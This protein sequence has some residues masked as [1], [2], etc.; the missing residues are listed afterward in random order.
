MSSLCPQGP[1]GMAQDRRLG[2]T[3]WHHP[4]GTAALVDKGAS[5]EAGRPGLAA[6][7]V[8]GDGVGES[9]GWGLRRSSGPRSDL[10]LL[11]AYEGLFR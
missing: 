4:V 9:N 11:W 5:E 1:E 7:E 3:G 6:P 8:K 10:G 2:L